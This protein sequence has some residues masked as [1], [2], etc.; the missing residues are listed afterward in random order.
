MTC[1]L[2]SSVNHALD[3]TFS[4]FTTLDVFRW[5]P[6]RCTTR[7]DAGEDF[8]GHENLRVDFTHRTDSRGFHVSGPRGAGVLSKGDGEATIRRVSDGHFDAAACDDTSDNQLAGAQV[9]EDIFDVRAVE[10]SAT[11]FGQ[12]DLVSNRRY[13]FAEPGFD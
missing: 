1:K 3:C 12:D 6:R 4:T 11:G 9:T 7:I 8:F 5:S 10:Y 13:F 2:N